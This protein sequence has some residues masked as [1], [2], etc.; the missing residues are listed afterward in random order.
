MTGDIAQPIENNT[1]NIPSVTSTKEP[2]TP[3]TEDEAT[4]SSSEVP[5]LHQRRISAR[6]HARNEL[7]SKT[8]QFE[9]PTPKDPV[10][11]HQE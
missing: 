8:V 1:K 5:S 3:D 10:E 11:V 2:T 4:S 6:T 9:T 7:Q